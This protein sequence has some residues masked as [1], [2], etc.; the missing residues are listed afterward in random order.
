MSRLLEVEEV[1][2]DS[3]ANTVLALDG[4]TSHV[5][6]VCPWLSLLDAGERCHFSQSFRLSNRAGDR[7]TGGASAL[8]CGF[9][10]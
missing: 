4:V 3:L 1:M 10:I 9:W 8:I 6:S 5:V 2:L 7:S